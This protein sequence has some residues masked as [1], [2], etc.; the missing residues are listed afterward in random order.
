MRTNK[1]FAAAAITLRS[2]G[3]IEGD[4]P[5]QEGQSA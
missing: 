4:G 2:A 5:S 1:R 3:Y